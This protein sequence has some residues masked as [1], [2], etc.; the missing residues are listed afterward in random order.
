MKPARRRTNDSRVAAVLARERNALSDAL[1]DD[2]A[3]N[4]S[5]SINVRF[6][7]A[8]IAAFDRVVE[9]AINAVAIVLI[10]FRGI[11]S[12]LGRD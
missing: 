12:A 11:D 7:R 8:K 1:I 4:F 6:A 10:I 3:A 2:V 9:Q 5:E